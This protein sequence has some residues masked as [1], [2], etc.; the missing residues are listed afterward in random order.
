MSVA[1]G[2]P[3]AVDGFDPPVSVLDGL[4]YRFVDASVQVDGT[5]AL[6]LSDGSWYTLDPSGAVARTDLDWGW[7]VGVGDLEGDGLDDVVGSAP[8]T[9]RSCPPP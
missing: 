6:R 2:D 9:S 3:A 4:M 5:V 7:S 8:A 1:L